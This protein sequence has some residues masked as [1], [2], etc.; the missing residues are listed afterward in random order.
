[1][2][3][4]STPPAT[5]PITL[6]DVK[7]NLKVDTTDD[8]TLIE[9][10]IKAAREY[11]E[12]YTGRALLEQTIQERL[13]CFPIQTDSNLVGSIELRFAPLKTFTHLKYINSDGVETT[14]VENTDY[15]IDTFSEPPRIYPEYNKTWPTI[16]DEPLAVIIEYVAGY[17]T[18]SDVPAP[19]RKAM[20]L[21][22]AKMYEQR[23]DS[24]KNLPTMSRWLLNT[25]K[26]QHL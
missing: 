24:V 20:L 12:I 13:D 11:V 1:M 25:Q 16:R 19:I 23:E 5:E 22:V 7:N 4:V 8:D 6:T 2:Y 18:A 15:K 21:I 3:K 10:L 14:L 17:S 9:L 26:I